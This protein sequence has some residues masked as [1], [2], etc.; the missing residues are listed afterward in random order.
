MQEEVVELKNKVN[1]LTQENEY[2]KHIVKLFKEEKFGSKSEG[3]IEEENPQ[4]L[5]NE[6][7]QEAQG[8]QLPLEQEHIS[9]VRKKGRGKKK[10]FPEHLPREEKIIDI[11]ESDKICPHDGTRLK[12]IG[13]DVVEKI[14]TVPAQSSIVE[15][16]TLKYA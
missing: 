3:Y 9:Y 11:E 8:E 2:L 14:K 15:E 10:P 1:F 7:E 4:L 5:F 16:K 13:F 6:L 12:Q